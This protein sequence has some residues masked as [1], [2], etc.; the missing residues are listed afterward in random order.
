MGLR[1]DELVVGGAA[2]AGGGVG[3]AEQLVVQAPGAG[4]F[5]VDGVHPG[6]VRRVEVPRVAVRQ[7]GAHQVEQ[8]VERGCG[9][10]ADDVDLILARGDPVAQVLDVGGREELENREDAGVL[11]VVVTEHQLGAA[12]LERS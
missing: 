2:E 10:P 11:V 9:R 12:D 8:Q 4:R 5:A 1:E 7:G 6:E 3:E